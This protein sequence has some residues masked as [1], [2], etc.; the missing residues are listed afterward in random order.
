MRRLLLVVVLLASLF[1]VLPAQAQTDLVLEKLDIGLWPEYDRADVL[2][3]YWITLPSDVSL[4][5][6]MS[7][8]IPR[9]SGEPYNLAMKD[10]DGLLYNLAYTTEVQNDWI[11]VTFSTPSTEVQ[12]EYYDSGLTKDGAVR[13]YEYVWPG[14]YEVKNVS[15]AIQQPVNATNMQIL[16]DFGAG[17]L[18]DDGLMYYNK[19]IGS[20]SA[21]TRVTVRFSY[22]KPDDELSFGSQAV[23]PVQP[24]S[25]SEAGRV[26]ASTISPW[27]IGG[28]G[29]LL[30]AGG[31]SWFLLTRNQVLDT[32][33]A[34]KRRHR[35]SSHPPAKAGA[36]TGASVYCSQCGRKAPST[37]AFCR[38][39]GNRLRAD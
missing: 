34:G 1:M 30:L 37:D 36:D 29:L 7:I 35:A 26:K 25:T 31:L 39:C 12:L 9:E 14:D 5:A 27:I 24:A 20:V 3:I 6:Q 28:L 4:P 13:N 23:Q 19:D 17:T 8:R 18:A 38:S 10:V 22:N 15:L 33:K 32:A 11:K 21:G 16:P 2:V